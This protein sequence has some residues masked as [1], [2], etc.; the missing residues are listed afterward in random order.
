MTSTNH[1]FSVVLPEG[2]VDNSSY[3][4]TGPGE[5]GSQQNI[6]LNVDR[7]PGTTDVSLYAQERIDM[8]KA[9]FPSVEI[10]KS[11]P[12]VL[13]SRASAFELVYTLDKITLRKQVFILL[14]GVGYTFA[15][16]FSPRS[17]KTIGTF[18]KKIANS[19]AVTKS[20]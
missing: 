11:E 14:Q 1:Q 12:L 9:A 6:Y 19:L 2:W 10:L 7:S 15:G 20:T 18:V 16:D 4:F 17:I 13:D 5:G 8:L 3:L